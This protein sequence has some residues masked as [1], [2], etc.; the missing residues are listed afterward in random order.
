MRQLEAVTELE[1]TEEALIEE[2]E[3]A[4]STIKALENQLG[5][6]RQL[7]A[8]TELE[9][10]E[11]ALIE[12]L[13]TAASTIKALENQLGEMR[14]LELDEESTIEELEL[15]ANVIAKLE[16]RNVK[17]EEMVEGD[18][19]SLRNQKQAHIAEFAELKMEL[20][21]GRSSSVSCANGL[22]AELNDKVA[23]IKALEAQLLDAQESAVEIVE[24][25]NSRT[26]QELDSALQKSTE[27]ALSLQIINLSFIKASEEY[28]ASSSNDK[29][30]ITRL[31]KQIAGLKLKHHML[32]SKEKEF[33]N[34]H[35]LLEQRTQQLH[36]DERVIAER[37]DA[38]HDLEDELQKSTD[39]L[40]EVE[41]DEMNLIE[42][43]ENAEE[44]IAKQQAVI[45]ELE[46][47]AAVGSEAMRGGKE[48]EALKLRMKD[49]EISRDEAMMLE[50]QREID[51]L[52]AEMAEMEDN[53]AK[54]IDG[55]GESGLLLAAAE[56]KLAAKAELQ[57]DEALVEELEASEVRLIES[58]DESAAMLAAVEQ[59]EEGLIALLEAS[60]SVV[61]KLERTSSELKESE[62]M[63]IEDRDKCAAMLA[64]VESDEADL[65]SQLEASVGTVAELK[66]KLAA[67]EEDGDERTLREKVI[68]L[69]QEN[70][71]LLQ[72][73]AA[74]EESEAK[75]IAGLDK[76]AS[77]LAAKEQEVSAIE[78]DEEGLI[79]LVAEL[80]SKLAA[81]ELE[82][83]AFEQVEELKIQLLEKLKGD[84]MMLKGRLAV[85]KR[86]NGEL[87]SRIEQEV[88][89]LV[90]VERDEADLIAQLEASAATVSA[91]E[92]TCSTMEFESAQTIADIEHGEADLIAQLEASAATIHE[93]EK[94]LAAKSSESEAFKQVEQLK[95]QM[96]HKEIS[97]DE[98]QLEKLRGDDD[99]L[100]AR[101]V[102]VES[103]N[104]ALRT[105]V[106]NEA[107]HAANVERDEADL[108]AQ[109]EASA[110]LVAE[111]E[112]KLA[113]KSSEGE[114]LKQVEEL[115]IQ[116]K[117]KELQR[118]QTIVRDLMD[119]LNDIERDEASLIAQLE[120]SAATI[121]E[122]EKS[123]AAKSSE[124]EAFRQMEELKLK[125]KELQQDHVLV[126]ELEQSEAHLI[127][128]LD[129]SAT[130]LAEKE[131]ELQEVEHDE[132]ALISQLDDSAVAIRSL[133]ARLA[134]TSNTDTQ[135][136]Q[137]LLAQIHQLEID[138]AT[139]GATAIVMEDTEARLVAQLESATKS[140][141]KNEVSEAN[142]KH[143]TS[144]IAEL[145]EIT[146]ER[147]ALNQRQPLGKRVT[148]SD[149]VTPP[150]SPAG[151]SRPRSFTENLNAHQEQLDS[152]VGELDSR[153]HDM[154]EILRD[155]SELEE[156][157]KQIADLTMQ[158]QEMGDA[159]DKPNAK[160]QRTFTENLNAHQRQIDDLVD[161]LDASKLE[162]DSVRKENIE[163]D[164]IRK[165]IESLR[166]QLSRAGE[167]SAAL[168]DASRMEI[169]SL[170]M[171]LSHAG[172][173]SA[174]DVQSTRM[175]LAR[176]VRAK[177]MAAARLT[178]AETEIEEKAKELMR[179]KKAATERINGF[180]VKLVEAEATLK[181]TEA[182]RSSLA[183]EVENSEEM[184]ADLR[185]DL[186]TARRAAFARNSDLKE[187]NR[188]L[189]EE[190]EALKSA[191]SNATQADNWMAGAQ[192]RIAELE[193][194]EKALVVEMD[195]K[196]GEIEYLKH[197]LS[198]Q[199]ATVEMGE[200]AL[201]THLAEIEE[202]QA[203]GDE[204]Q[205]RVRGLEDEA[206][207]LR[208]EKIEVLKT[209][210]ER[211]S[212]EGDKRV[213]LQKELVLITTECNV[214][215]EE[216]SR[217]QATVEM[218]EGEEEE[219]EGIVEGDGEK[220]RTLQDKLSAEEEREK[221]LEETVESLALIDDRV[222]GEKE[223]LVKQLEEGREVERR[224]RKEL[225]AKSRLVD[226]LEGELEIV[227]NKCDLL[228]KTKK[229]VAEDL[230]DVRGMEEV[231]RKEGKVLREKLELEESRRRTAEVELDTV[232]KRVREL[233][234]EREGMIEAGKKA[235]EW[236]AGAQGRISEMAREIEKWKKAM[237]EADETV[238]LESKRAGALEEEL[239]ELKAGRGEVGG[240][241]ERLQREGRVA[242]EDVEKERRESLEDVEREKREAKAEVRR[243]E[244]VLE[245]AALERSK[246]E[247]TV[248]MMESS[249]GGELA[250]V[251]GELERLQ[252]EGRVALEGVE[253]ERRQSL[254]DEERRF[255]ELEI[256]KSKLEA[257]VEIMEG[258]RE[259]LER[260]V[261]SEKR[262][263]LEIMEEEEGRVREADETAELEA[264]RGDRLKQELDELR[265]Q[266]DRLRREGGGG[267]GGGEGARVAAEIFAPFHGAS[268]E[269]PEE[270]KLALD[271]MGAKI[272]EIAGEESSEV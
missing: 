87:L 240:E 244:M 241:L 17:L 79:S 49:P 24:A 249:S 253:K 263:S 226:D 156:A 195:T 91:L 71:T 184:T 88:R 166:L 7:E 86:E 27:E 61:A 151:S 194:G 186:E 155:R 167:E 223:D 168:E 171:Q 112:K 139:L 122:L 9:S 247:A 3:T 99:G 178:D 107:A 147:D 242:L 131:H 175:E 170:K 94:S 206:S 110:V 35:R 48:L 46:L 128:S 159:R 245:A 228:E 104:V 255:R 144:L 191:K 50:L 233:E 73:M 52:R 22:H 152:L 218:M 25:R 238:E 57:K 204:L 106:E 260:V 125:L 123:L 103:E 187:A 163:I 173:D 269:T 236:M 70:A 212:E 235:D 161:Q 258:G 200:N 34:E 80:E 31:E 92:E 160:R 41:H 66:R 252:R 148:F 30:Q 15:A 62:A 83:E 261:E 210:G 182:T 133:E 59:D 142:V 76:S 51:V 102:K 214:L 157:Q 11:E 6:M 179:Q 84:D 134:A 251:R 248:F 158:L 69:E 111:L 40:E 197:Q 109:L 132:V 37:E 225:V 12:E 115:K 23:E 55:L 208:M 259:E 67:K 227:R 77:L 232:K 183:R 257:T 90:S 58:L 26:I 229:S 8:V 39:I 141:A 75:L 43:L 68:L 211:E 135:N 153:K 127:D 250:R 189:A 21:S 239:E 1:S 140:L 202:L 146:A 222:E 74:V 117:N 97:K 219:L 220:I 13:E 271:E 201:T 213:G 196:S 268:W 188:L 234:A 108:I 130:L 172:E 78:G 190:R 254:E 65:I 169:A 217:F 143:I 174:L 138:N 137:N 150:A 203:G 95:L 47:N 119:K 230:K 266:Y 209:A 231:A 42:R 126:G 181:V 262:K 221:T 114:A 54:L 136:D 20:E 2:L 237:E 205:A 185:N 5:E 243:L 192:G 116:V 267:L 82:S 162:M 10:T 113:A 272:A 33:Q 176:A 72:E 121:D 198:Q 38:I 193:S 101:L 64:E 224:I 105:R 85:L 60:A 93:L 19:E 256:E 154:E 63:L 120:T 164:A 36:D 18:V 270:Y 44:V 98:E 16:K 199:A 81:K 100:R 124:G 180:E 96:K 56:E 265:G 129:Q 4:A 14:Q 215:R 165:E 264:Q 89:Q 118:D 216:V 28:I 246:L 32:D 53:E 145:D 45:H 149:D 29:E 207:R 177:G